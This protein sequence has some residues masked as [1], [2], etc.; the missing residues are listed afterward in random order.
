MLELS[1][2]LGFRL[3]LTDRLIE[4]PDLELTLSC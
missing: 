4:E 3:T 1:Q 2:T